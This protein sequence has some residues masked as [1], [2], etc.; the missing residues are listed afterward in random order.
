RNVLDRVDDTDATQLI[1]ARSA[2]EKSR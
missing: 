2:P 1:E